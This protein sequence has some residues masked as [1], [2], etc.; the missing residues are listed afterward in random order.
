MPGLQ[1]SQF[2]F[3]QGG[4]Q[5]QQPEYRDDEYGNQFHDQRPIR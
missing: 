5:V 4:S 3:H 1:N 2:S